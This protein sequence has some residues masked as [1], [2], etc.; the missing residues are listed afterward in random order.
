MEVHFVGCGDAFGSGGR[1]NTCFHVTGEAANFLIDCGA[2]SLVALK[3]AGVVLNDIRVI[4]ITHFHADH[5]GGIPSFML[6]AQFFSKRTAPLTIVG[7][8]GLKEWFV[9]A[10]ETAFPGSSKTQPKFDLELL[11]LSERKTVPIDDLAVTPFLVRHGPP[12]GPF[13]AFRI[14]AEGRIIAYTG[15]TEWTDALIEAG[16]EADLFV[17][18][19]YF[20]DK[21]VPLHL[22]L[23]SLEAHLPE[24]RPK[25]LILTHMSEEML[26]QRADVPYECAADGLR[27]V[28]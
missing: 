13:F 11:E 21:K 28:I 15:D 9:R 22:D 8:A 20:R 19:A 4:L 14:E 25:R 23:A 12:G 1:F 5:F 10:M 6:D 27:V 16:R 3:R 2:S 26:G 7:P 24:I 17:A 18:E